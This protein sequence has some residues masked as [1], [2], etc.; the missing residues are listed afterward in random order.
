M[1]HLDSGTKLPITAHTA[2]PWR[3]H[4]LTKDFEI[5]DVWRLPTPGGRD[6]L[7]RL[8]QQIASGRRLPLVVRSL[9]AVRWKLGKVFGWDKAGSGVG[10]RVRSPRIG[11]SRPSG[12]TSR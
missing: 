9:F 2:R 10:G 4:E 12:A 1:E 3:V 5:E 11:C 8:V 6:D 7:A